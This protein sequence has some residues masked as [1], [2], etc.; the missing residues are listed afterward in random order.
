[1]LFYLSSISIATYAPAARVVGCRPLTRRKFMPEEKKVY[2]NRLILHEDNP[3][4]EGILDE[5]KAITALCSSEKILELA[6]D[7]AENGLSPLERFM[8]FQEDPEDAPDDANFV[9]AEGNR[10]LC[11][12]KLLKD[13]KRAP[14]NVREMFKKA[15]KAFKAPRTVPVVVEEDEGER[16]KWI[17]RAHAGAMEGR[18]RKTWDTHQK[19][20]FFQNP[21]NLRGQVL[22]DYAVAR[23]FISKE[24][25]AGRLSHVVRLIGNPVMRSTIGL[26]FGDEPTELFRN[27]PLEDFDKLLSWLLAEA[28]Q[29]KAWLTSA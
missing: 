2:L 26:T 21:R 27:R 23:G 7:I 14:A 19:T 29:K 3:R 12:L 18:G 1:M 24:D 11:A 20:R 8:V 25:T 9:V 16:R 22:L 13:P 4:F 28:L 15:A 5:E 17:E 6:K 10:R